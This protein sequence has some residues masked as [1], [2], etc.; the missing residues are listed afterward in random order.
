MNNEEKILHILEQMQGD[1]SGLTSDVGTLKSEVGTLKTDVGTLRSGFYQLDKK[2]DGNHKEVMI[3][4]SSLEKNQEAIKS[5]ILNS[6]DTFRKSEEA[7]NTI[8]KF[9][10]VFSK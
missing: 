4:L 10:E 2:V 9:K 8:Q 5:F 6:D 3:K 7:Y 1:I